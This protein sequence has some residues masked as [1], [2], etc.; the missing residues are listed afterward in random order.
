MTGVR[1]ASVTRLRPRRAGRPAGH[2][3]AR[4]AEPVE[5]FVRS[6][7]QA[8]THHGRT[9]HRAGSTLVRPACGEQSFSAL[10][11]QPILQCYYDDQECRRCLA[12]L[13]IRTLVSV[14][15]P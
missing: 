1:I 13:G 9:E 14:A 6:V 4:T 8:D 7:R 5:W 2:D 11:Q 3:A 12:L 10:N 15:A